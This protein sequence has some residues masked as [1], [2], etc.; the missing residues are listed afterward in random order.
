MTTSAFNSWGTPPRPAEALADTRVLITGISGYVASWAAHEALEV[1]YTVVGTVRDPASSKVQFLRDAMD[2]KPKKGFSANAA[3]KLSLVQA[4]LTAGEEAWDDILSQGYDAVMHIASPYVTAKVTDESAL[5]RPAVDGTTSILKACIKHKVKRVVVTSSIA[6]VFDPVEEGK[7]YSAKDWS[8]DALQAAYGK[9]KTLAEKAAWKTVEGTS[10]Q[11]CTLC[12]T[13]IRGPA[14]YTDP[15]MYRTFESGDFAVRVLEGSYKFTHM[16]NGVVDVRDLGRA[17][18]FAIQSPGAA[19]K[20]FITSGPFKM[21][22]ESM[23][24]I[25]RM[26]PNYVINQSPMPAWMVGMAR[27]DVK[28]MIGKRCYLDQSGTTA[29]GNLAPG[30]FTFRPYEETFKDMCDDVIAVVNPKPKQ[31]RSCALQ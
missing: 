7:M 12:P 14:L 15:G 23:E 10:V 2:G 31:N 22:A 8:N 29:P 5:I 20:R 18:V 11:L 16:C 25:A 21:Y 30:G 26:Y 4:D 24:T 13:G 17:H 28:T 1:G 3:T 19:G 27:P 9:S 6:A